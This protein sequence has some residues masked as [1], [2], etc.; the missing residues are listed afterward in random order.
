MLPQRQRPIISCGRIIA[1]IGLPMLIVHPS[2]CYGPFQFPEKFIPLVILSAL[3]N[4]PIPIYGDGQQER[5]WLFGEG[6]CRAVRL[7]L[8]RAAPGESFNVATAVE[9]ANLEVVREICATV[10]RQL[11]RDPCDSSANRI[12]HVADRPGHDPRYALETSKIRELGWTP[13][14]GLSAGLKATV[15]WYV[16]NRAWQAEIALRFDRS[17]RLGLT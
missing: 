1:P 11:A 5:D 17:R 7:I 8:K 16:E 2:N 4:K 14:V 10:D 9:R 12:T 15:Q 6:L 3:E 13:S